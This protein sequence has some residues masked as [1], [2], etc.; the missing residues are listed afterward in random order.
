MNHA[1]VF[2]AGY[3][4]ILAR[5]DRLDPVAYSRTRNFLNGAVTRLSPYI[6]RGIITLPEILQHLQQ[7]GYQRST[8]EKLVQ[9]LCW[10]EYFQRVWQSLGNRLWS[11]IKQPQQ[12]VQ[13]HQ[14]P[15]ALE[16]ASTGIEAIDTAIRELY[17]VGYMH[18]HLRMYIAG[19]TCNLGRAHWS[20][21]ARWMYYH[22]LD[23]DLASNTCSWQ[24][25]AG[26][27]SAKKYLANQENINRY[28]GTRQSGTFLDHSY[29]TIFSQ[30]VPESL[31]SI[32]QT[33]LTTVLP[34]T[35]KPVIDPSIPVLLYNSYHLHP[36]WRREEKANR[37][38]LLEPSHFQ[39]YPVSRKVLDFIL[40]LAMENI[41]GIQVAVMEVNELPDVQDA[42]VISMEHPAAAHYPGEKDPY[43]WLLPTLSG[44]YPSFSA[45]W[46]K[47]EKQLF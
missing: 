6:S 7:K 31:Q 30:G 13:H 36:G 18:N 45:F 26:T 39:Q 1:G 4:A 20:A 33:E 43:P 22:L 29:D 11:D 25:V 5:L 24:W 40:Q 16:K 42:T 8:M 3:D 21:P 15:L 44:Y 32:S 35:A 9:E 47:A 28:C 12:P 2:P 17:E 34:E 19:I 10:R 27:F 46:K 14:L 41:P 37:I 23:G 38:L